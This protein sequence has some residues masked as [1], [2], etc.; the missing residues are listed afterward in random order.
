M[1]QVDVAAVLRLSLD[2]VGE[3]FETSCREVDGFYRP[4]GDGSSH[5]ETVFSR[6]AKRA[7]SHQDYEQRHDFAADIL[8]LRLADA[9][10]R[11]ERLFSGAPVMVR[12]QRADD[13]FAPFERKNRAAV[14]NSVRKLTGAASAIRLAMVPSSAKLTDDEP[15]SKPDARAVVRRLRRPAHRD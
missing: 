2:Q 5:W 4:A 10:R 7:A 1:L 8:A 12:E 11:A 6:L 14:V 3:W 13:F 9:R 15:V